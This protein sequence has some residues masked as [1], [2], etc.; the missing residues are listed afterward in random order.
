MKN[1]PFCIIVFLATVCSAKTISLFN[2]EKIHPPQ[3]SL[4]EG[5]A[6]YGAADTTIDPAK[7]DSDF[8]G[9]EFLRVEPSGARVLIRFEQL[10]PCLGGPYFNI[11]DA[12]LVLSIAELPSSGIKPSDIKIYRVRKSWN[13]GGLDG[14]PNYW[15]ATYNSRYHSA[16]DNVIKWG[17][18]GAKSS[19]DIIPVKGA[20]VSIDNNKKELKISGLEKNIQLFLNRNYEDFGW[21]IVW[22]GKKSKNKQLEFYSCE[23]VDKSKRPVL[24]LEYEKIAPPDYPIDL[25]VVFIEKYPEYYAWLDVGSYEQKKFRGVDVGILKEPEFVDVPKNPKPGDMIQYAAVIKNHGKEPI[26]GF[27]F[28]WNVNDSIKKTGTVNRVLNSQ[29]EWRIYFSYP[30]PENLKD[31]RDEFITLRV[32]PIGKEKENK[33]NNERTI[34]T[35][36]RALGIHCD[37]TSRKFYLEYYNAYGTYSFEDWIQFQVQYWNQ[38]YFAKS[39]FKDSNPDAVLPRV[40]IQRISFFR[41]NVLA[42]AVHIA[43]DA[44]DPRYDGMWG[45][46]FATA[47][48]EDLNNPN[49]FFRK[50]LRMCEPSLIHELSHQCFGLIDIYWM[51]M[52]AAKNADTGEGGKV[53]LHDPRNPKKYLTGIGYWP[54]AGGLM[55]GGDTRY[56]PSHESTPLYSEHSVYG[57]NANAP[58][59]GGFFG[60]YLYGLQTNVILKVTDEN[61]KPVTGA[62]IKAWQSTYFTGDGIINDDKEV[63]Q[64]TLNKKGEFTL[65]NQTILEDEPYTTLTG[66]TLRDNPFGRIHVCG[67]NGNILFQLKYKGQ[68]YYHMLMAW[69]LNVEYA[70]GSKDTYIHD[71]KLGPDSRIDS[72]KYTY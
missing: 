32:E 36:G 23:T 49:W 9:S 64:G 52:E 48:K 50:T 40:R 38:I 12:S 16:K 24:V 45:W 25:G 13:E 70:K 39:R 3:P 26:S 55:G 58:Y 33:N 35:K 53:K 34:F 28:R 21:M 62:E 65:P 56:S 27:H 37:E 61:G 43:F 2:G 47:K 5:F 60:D 46:D 59:R 19:S 72:Y 20:K 10:L 7:S 68:Y 63:F 44:R 4:D 66:H 1:L 57:L 69:Q 51:T 29:D 15:A 6:Y 17:K 8:G 42:G 54:A 18:P 71:W 14:K 11:K 67:F 31:H 22:N 30:A 41:D